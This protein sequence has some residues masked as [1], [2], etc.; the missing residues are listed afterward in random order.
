[1]GNFRL[2]P[3]LIVISALV[4]ASTAHTQSCVPPPQGLRAWWRAEGN[5]LDSVGTNHAVPMNN[6]LYSGGEV[7]TGFTFSGFA[8]DYVA[9]PD[10]VF[11]YPSNGQTGSAPFS[12]E[13]WF[14]TTR[15]GA[16]L[17]QQAGIPFGSSL[18]G[19]VAGLYVGTNGTL[20]CAM[21]WDNGKV[22]EST[23]TVNDGLFHHAAVTYNGSIEALYLDGALVGSVPFVQRGY[24]GVYNYEL[25][26]AYTDGWTNT[27]E[28]WFPLQ[29][30][31]DEVSLYDRALTGGEVAAIHNAGS[32]G[33]CG[34]PGGPLLRHRYSFDG[35]AGTRSVLDSA[36][37]ANG[38]LTF[39]TT[40]SP[41]T[42]G[43]ADGSSFSGAGTLQ[44][45]G[46]NGYVTLPPGLISSL[47][48]LTV[49][50]WVTWNGPATSAWQRIFDFGLS[51]RGP[52]APGIGINY[53]ILCPGR[54]GTDLLGFEE[55]TVNPFG[56]VVDPD[57]LILLGSARLPI[58]QAV[59]L[60]LTYDPSAGQ[61]KLF[62]NG[63]LVNSATGVFN[64]M[65]RFAD[66]NN[67]LGRSQWIA[68]PFFNGSYDEF[69]LWEGTLSPSDITSHYNAGPDQPFVVMRPAL[70]IARSG[71]SALLSW[72]ALNTA[73]F[74]LQSTVALWPVNWINV[75]N[76]PTVNNSSYQVTL[77]ATGVA[78]YYRLQ[79]Q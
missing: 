23:S 34:L 48:N 72:P 49:E 57:S 31:I 64:A 32:A 22:I 44:L 41:Y 14:R 70:A 5:G 36:G 17:G 8:N 29:G 26:T 10:N 65:N 55:T 9:L 67:W 53:V 40:N 62:L 77:P 27:P 68:D 1:M 52:N 18:S 74:K 78:S 11:P 76:I 16:I 19:N 75:T 47:S 35:A 30:V 21:F 6:L 45:R 66:V 20:H 15:D 46:T 24:A 3:V 63:A 38:Y 33:K 60:A 13:L 4:V 71:T 43:V 28:G 73:S 7:G 39:G 25:G 79:S 59:Y 54:G 51:D 56:S 50:A 37:G 42:N 12:L 58:A 2:G 61:C 69:R